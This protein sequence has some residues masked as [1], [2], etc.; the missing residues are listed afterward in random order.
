MESLSA[1]SLFPASVACRL[2]AVIP[3]ITKSDF[4]VCAQ[5][6]IH[7]LTYQNKL[8]FYMSS[9]D[10]ML[11]VVY[12]NQNVKKKNAFMSLEEVVQNYLKQSKL[13]CSTAVNILTYI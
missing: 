5:T 6:H 1:S 11:V 10:D 8:R 3:N 12:V 4:D 7:T 9:S 13:Q 2:A